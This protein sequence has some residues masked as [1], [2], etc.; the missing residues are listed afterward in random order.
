MILFIII[1]D[2]MLGR[3]ISFFLI[4]ISALLMFSGIYIEYDIFLSF[5]VNK[6]N[7][8]SLGDILLII[9]KVPLSNSNSNILWKLRE[10][11]L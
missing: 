9:L 1:G 2:S 6:V 10:G 11:L 7:T 3:R 5:S 8:P 4:L